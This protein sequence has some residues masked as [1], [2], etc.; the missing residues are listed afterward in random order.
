MTA[1][2]D[3]LD[4]LGTVNPAEMG[5]DAVH[6]AVF[7]ATSPHYLKPG[8]RV[9]LIRDDRPDWV[10][11]HPKT[12]IGIVDPFLTETVAS[13]ERFW[14]FVLPRTTTGLRHVWTHP[15]FPPGT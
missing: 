8:Q 9:G 12:V 14:V 6:I 3:A 13:G 11:P 5:R 4:T 15:A 1:P 10:S 7:Q 2:K